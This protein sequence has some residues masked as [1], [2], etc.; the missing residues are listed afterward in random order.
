MKI[1]KLG[2]KY[3][4]IWFLSKNFE[5]KQYYLLHY[6]HSAPKTIAQS[7]E[8]QRDTAKG[9]GG[10]TAENEPKRVGATLKNF[11]W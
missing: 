8:N 3:S 4:K 7:A 6:E 11:F 9:Y 1:N 5:Q 2:A 10:I